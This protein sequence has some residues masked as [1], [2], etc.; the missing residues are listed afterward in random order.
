VIVAAEVEVTSGP[1]PQ[2]TT[3]SA[4]HSG[5][6]VDLIEVRGNWVRLAL[7]DGVVEGWV[8]AAAVEA[9]DG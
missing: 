6:E 8:P 2:Y 3:V 9:I 7:P 5:A 4:L 1:G